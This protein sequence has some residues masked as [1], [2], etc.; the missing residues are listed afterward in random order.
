MEWQIRD[1]IPMPPD[2]P[3]S[4]KWPF[5]RMQVGQ[6][7]R[8]D[9]CE[10]DWLPA[11][12]AAQ[13]VGKRNGWKFR[14]KWHKNPGDQHGLIWRVACLLLVLCGTGQ[15]QDYPAP[16]VPCC[17]GGYPPIQTTAPDPMGGNLT[18]KR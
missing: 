18:I 15:A 10:R 3:K 16:P 6:S 13:S 2:K 9:I 4:R 1:D 14:C 8:I 12:R 7:L 17:N 5:A 11:T